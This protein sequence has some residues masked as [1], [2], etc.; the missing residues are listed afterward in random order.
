NSLRQAF[1]NKTY[2]AQYGDNVSDAQRQQ[3]WHGFNN[4]LNIKRPQ[5]P[6]DGP[7]MTLTWQGTDPQRIAQWANEYVEMAISAAQSELLQDL[8]SAVR[9]RL[10]STQAQID[11][12]R[13]VALIDHQGRITQIKEALQLAESIGLD[14]PP[15]S[16]NL[17][18]SYTGSTSYLR[19]AKALRSELVLMEQRQR[20]DP[21]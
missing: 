1:F 4:T 11:T 3:L 5:K 18:T 21:Y 8:Q 12:L 2:L 17:I 9:L 15:P 7:Q 6:T 13:E 20:H 19:G 10:D 14:V 16:G